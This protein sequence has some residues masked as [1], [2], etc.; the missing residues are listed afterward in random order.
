MKKKRKLVVAVVAALVI[1]AGVLFALA[2]KPSIDPVAKPNVALTPTLIAQGAR[3][4]ALGDC[5]VCHTAPDGADYAG[6]LPLKTPFGIIYTTNITP[7]RATGIGT[8]SLE[9]FRRAM[10]Q[11]VSR[12]GHL[13][14]PAFPYIHYTK[15]TDHDIEAAYAF[16][17]TRPAAYAPARTNE[18]PLP[19]RFRPSLAFWNLLYLRE[20]A[21]PAASDSPVDRGKYLVEGLGHCSSCHTMMGVIGGEKRREYMQGG[22]VDQWSA[23]ALDQLA[24]SPHPWVAQQIADYLSTGLAGEHGA[25]AGPMR[26]V[27]E[28]LR[29]VPREDVEAIAAYLLS[30]QQ[31]WRAPQSSAALSDLAQRIDRG[32]QVFAGACAECHDDGSPMRDAM[33][34]P[35][36]TMSS[37][38]MSPSPRNFVMTVHKGLAWPAQ[39]DHTVYMPPFAD[40]LTDQQIADL[41]TY[42]RSTS[43]QPTP[44]PDLDKHVAELREKSP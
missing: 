7:D 30:L 14:Y 25:A 36:L 19:L 8:W 28:N 35:A 17:M 39:P 24:A 3:V 5:V 38:V 10:R 9:A 29:R 20:G 23:P 31:P 41:A 22:V 2:I 42:V 26:P 18:L 1:G 32:K 27:T 16:L 37:A 44:W 21:Q 33:G 13:L 34:R 15:V 4:V 6:G 40:V 43:A 11:G 12:D